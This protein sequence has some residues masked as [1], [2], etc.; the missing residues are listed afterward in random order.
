[1]QFT[2]ERPTIDHEIEG[3]QARYRSVIPFCSG[4]NVLDVGCGI[5]HGSNLLAN[6]ACKVT[7]Y[8]V[9]AEAITEAMERYKRPNLSFS[10]SNLDML[11]QTHELI[12]MIE[13]IEH[14]EHSEALAFIKKIAE[15]TRPIVGTTPNGILFPYHP[16][17]P[18]EYRGYH[19]WHFTLDELT[20]VLKDFY[21]FYE[22]YGHMYDPRIN[23]FTS[24]T[25]YGTFI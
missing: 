8:D 1:M 12:C 2:G 14:F 20:G 25:F 15:Y 5:G 3:S 18:G 22:V 6:Y 11:I 16:M 4:N 23:Q 19:K 13:S 10:C 9:C 7:G 21:P 24:Y 17:N